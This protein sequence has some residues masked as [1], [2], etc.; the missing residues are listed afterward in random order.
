MQRVK[1][2]LP[3]LLGI[4][5]ATLLF[6]VLAGYTTFDYSGTDDAP[7][8][9]AFMGYEGGEPAHYSML[10]HTV[11]AWVLWGLAKLFPGIAWFSIFQLFFLWFSSVVVVKSFSRCAV[12]HHRPI[13]VGAL[14]GVMAM[15]AGALFISCRVSFTTTAAWLGAAAVA[16]LASVDWANGTG[17]AIRRGMGLSTLLLVLCYFLRQVSVL[18]PLAFW[19]LGLGLMALTLRVKGQPMPWLKPMLTGAAVCLSCLLVLTGI[20]VAETKL[21]QL[22]EFYAWQDS[23]SQLLDYSDMDSTPP[24]DE[25]LAEIGWSRDEY[26][27][28]TFWYFMD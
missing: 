5:F 17:R 18:P 28:F 8:L 12:L 20:R 1:K 26:T 7:I 4:L 15:L 14:A 21:L 23:S 6:A 9:R 16:Q 24:T 13:W 3:W 25:A 19:L 2:M 10:V 27:L 11:M 22:D